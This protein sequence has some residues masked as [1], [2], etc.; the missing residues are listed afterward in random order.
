MK[1]A[2][3]RLLITCLISI[4]FVSVETSA[5][6]DTT[7]EDRLIQNL[8]SGDPAIRDSDDQTVDAIRHCLDDPE[9]RVR[10]HAV[11][12]LSLLQADWLFDELEQ[13]VNDADS[14]VRSEACRAVG[15]LASR[16]ES[17]DPGVLEDLLLVEQLLEF[18]DWP[19]RPAR[20]GG[21]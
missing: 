16:L 18:L 17:G 8:D 19:D 15:S 3:D 14:D 2:F 21:W 5:Q 6:S 10:E 11:S 12:L 20:Y 4:L 13:L 1:S 7:I 9:A